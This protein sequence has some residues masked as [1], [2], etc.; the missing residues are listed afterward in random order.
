MPKTKEKLPK[1]ITKIDL[2][3]DENIYFED[4]N[5]FDRYV[6]DIDNS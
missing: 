5:D 4:I 1:V 3:E 2:I 6:D